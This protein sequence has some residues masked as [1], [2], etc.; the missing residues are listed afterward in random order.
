MPTRKSII[1]IEAEGG[2]K[3]LSLLDL[4]KSKGPEAFN[5]VEESMPGLR[6]AMADAEVAVGQLRKAFADGADPRFARALQNA[7][8][9]LQP[10]DR[11]L[12]QAAQAEKVLFEA[13]DRGLISQARAVELSTLQ[14]QALDAEILRLDAAASARKRL[15]DAAAAARA[16][17]RAD[18]ANAQFNVVL[19]VADPRPGAARA[20]AS[21][22][23]EAEAAAV[24]YGNAVKGVGEKFRFTTTEA[25]IFQSGIINTVQSLAAGASPA[26]TF[27][28]Q[29]LQIAPAFT[30]VAA[31]A[32]LFA[33]AVLGVAAAIGGAGAAAELY[34]SRQRDLTVAL[35]AQG[36]STGLTRSEIE[37]LAASTSAAGHVSVAG[38]REIAG[39]AAASG[40]IQGE[41]YRQLIRQAEDYAVLVGKSLPEATAELA[42]AVADPEKGV[43]QLDDAFNIL[44]A[45]QR[46]NIISL[47]RQGEQQ[48]AQKQ[49]LEALNVR[50]KNLA[51]DG[52]TALERAW[53]A[54]KKA[55]SDAIDATGKAFSQSQ[56][57]AE[58]L[59]GL[60]T[61]RPGPQALADL[62]R[63]R[64]ELTARLTSEQ[65]NARGQADAAANREEA[66][67]IDELVRASNPLLNVREQLLDNIKRLQAAQSSRS[68]RGPIDDP[69]N[70]TLSAAEIDRQRRGMEVVLANLRTPLEE[71]R[72]QTANA[73]RVAAAPQ[74]DQAALAARLDAETA[75]R[76]NL[77]SALDAEAI[78]REAARRVLIAEQ[79]ALTNQSAALAVQIS[80]T[81]AV[82]DAYGRSTEAAI[83]AQAAR[84]S[85]TE[86]VGNRAVNIDGRT[87]EVLRGQTA[88]AN[89]RGAASLAELGF[90][91]QGLRAQSAA[92]GD[93]AALQAVTRELEVQAATRQQLATAQANYAAAL[94]SGTEAE[95]RSASIALADAEGQI[96]KRRELLEVRDRET[97]T[98]RSQAELKANQDEIAVLQRSIDLIGVSVERRGAEIAVLREKQRLER[99]RPDLDEAT[100]QA[101]I[102]Q[103]RLQGEL[104]ARLRE[105]EEYASSL[106][107]T[108]ASAAE[109]A[110]VGGGKIRAVAQGV[111]QDFS[112]L[113][114]RRNV[115]KPLVDGL[116][117]VVRKLFEVGAASRS[118]SGSGG[119]GFLGLLGS[120]AGSIFGSFGFGSSGAAGVQGDGIVSS[121][122]L[123][124]ANGAAFDQGRVAA[125]RDGGLID[126]PTS[127]RFAGGK[128]IAGEA[129]TEAI[130]PLRRT[131][132]GR[133]GVETVSGRSGMQL[134]LFVTVNQQGNGGTAEDQAKSARNAASAFEAEFN[135]LAVKGMRPGG[136]FFRYKNEPG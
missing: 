77:A 69:N 98:V 27:S 56:T 9:N 78:G 60:K 68:G 59:A 130:M 83:R 74:A 122:T 105:E 64:A 47:A 133:L 53:G 127:F 99:E 115:T 11:A 85:L 31:S 119:G 110:L 71:A 49:L 24:A 50:S 13:R 132:S 73:A 6:K 52:L 32:G 86:A 117:D 114:F 12:R 63:R 34:L 101:L 55:A 72:A 80:A 25:A 61:T 111:L 103:A 4:I 45:T 10:L 43:R 39:A 90:A 88:S 126:R 128:G 134:N 48:E 5:A 54:V 28:T 106:R 70:P 96:A 107:Q 123:F 21:V 22:F 37:R 131:A 135:R 66:K 42:K 67:S 94:Q 51:T 113:F 8:E 87:R 75:A 108:F 18:Q 38:A 26:T 23:I 120:L 40:R 14:R 20:S 116:D 36:D 81:E 79:Q 16:Q 93:A 58:Q 129:G 1:R 17:E 109:E 62:E 112:R 30:R 19:G 118:V 125:F 46:R 65:I 15:G 95:I 121:G 102:E 92:G 57:T 41:V 33:G 104:N 89:E 44:D 82:T 100:R 91:N 35:R 29:L 7:V 2:D 3:L 97:Q 84:Q 136:I 76:R 124:A